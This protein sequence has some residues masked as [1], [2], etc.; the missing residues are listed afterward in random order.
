MGDSG[1][2]NEGGFDKGGDK[3]GGGVGLGLQIG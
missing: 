1:F 3:G 2:V